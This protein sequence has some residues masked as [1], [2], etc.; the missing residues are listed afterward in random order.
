MENPYWERVSKIAEKQ[1]NKG[2]KDYGQG[3]EM[4]PADIHTRIE[5]ALE[6]LVD[7][8]MYLCWID[9]KLKE[10]EN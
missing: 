4:N 5:M 9:D 10:K 6:E 1:R 7:L 8:A 2:I 3:I